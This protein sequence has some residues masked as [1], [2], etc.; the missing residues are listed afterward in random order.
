MVTLPTLQ[1]LLEAG[2]HFGHTE[3]RWHP[4]AASYIH[5]S[6]SGVHIINLEKTLEAFGLILPMIS[7]HV[8]SGKSI[9]FVSTKK[10]ASA[11][12]KELAESCG[13]PYMTA[14]WLG[15]L[16]T[17]FEV[18]KG[19][20]DHYR[21]MRHDHET[22]AW[23]KYTK[24]ERLDLERELAKKHTFLEGLINLRKIPEMLFIVDVRH[25]KTAL[26]EAIACGVPVVAIADTNINAERIT[27]PIPGNDDAV[28]SITLF[29]RLISEAV[30]EGAVARAQ[31]IEEDAA[32]KAAQVKETHEVVAQSI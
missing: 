19:M 20:L 28:K 21:K 11:V 26:N 14:R 30:K 15:G 32:V 25:E 17:N 16:L 22:L 6:R 10:Q 8:A 13:M 5:S 24:K 18:M 1:E 4:H 31:K 9:L 12:V 27:Y 7:A 29:T 3:G 2:A 23:E